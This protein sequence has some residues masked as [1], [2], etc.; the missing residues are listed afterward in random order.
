ML[1]RRNEAWPA[2]RKSIQA[3]NWGTGRPSREDHGPPGSRSRGA[4][5]KRPGGM[6]S[7]IYELC[8]LWDIENAFCRLKDFRRVH[9]R[10]DKTATSFLGFV[11]IAAIKKSYPRLSK[12]P[13]RRV[14]LRQQGC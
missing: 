3:T 7:S 5:I 9:T 4:R 1:C 12:K 6:A 11:T 8:R 14:R 10:Y 2:E 13:N